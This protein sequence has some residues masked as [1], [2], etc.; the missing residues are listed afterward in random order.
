MLFQ[1]FFLYQF[2]KFKKLKKNVIELLKLINLKKNLLRKACLLK[3]FA[4]TS[5]ETF[6]LV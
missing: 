5:F 2:Y 3:D 4:K 6:K 1:K